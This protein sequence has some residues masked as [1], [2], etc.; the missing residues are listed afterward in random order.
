M[1]RRHP[2]NRSSSPQPGQHAPTSSDAFRKPASTPEATKNL[3]KPAADNRWREWL[4][5]FAL[6]VGAPL[7]LLFI[8]EIPLRVFGYG[9]PASFFI[10]SSSGEKYITNEK[11]A[12]QFS[13]K[14]TP[15]K[16]FPASIPLRKEP[17]AIRI[18]VLGE[19]AAMGTPDPAFGLGRI[20]EVLLRREFP[21]R[22][23]EVIN[24][25][26]RGINSH[27]LRLI[28][29]ECATH[30]VDLFLVYMG[31]NEVI[32]LHGPGPRTPPWAQSRNLIRCSHWFASSKVG[33][34]FENALGGAGDRPHQDMDNFR[35][36]SLRADD[37]R[38]QKNRDIFEANLEDIVRA[39]T[40]SGAQVVLFTV[41]VNLKDFP[42]LQCLHRA[43][44][45]AADQ[46]RWEAAVKEGTE[47]A[48]RG[49]WREAA[50]KYSSALGL[51]DH[52]ADLHFRLAEALLA[53]DD[54]VRARE[55]YQLALDWDALQFR[56]DR[57]MNAVIRKVGGHYAGAG[58]VL[59]DAEEAFASSELSEHGIPGRRLFEDHVHPSFSGNYLLAC[60][61]YEQS[62]AA[63]G[64]ALGRSAAASLPTEA[65]C[66]DTLAYT[67]YDR[68][69][70]LAAMVR[71]TGVPP[72]LDQLN[73]AERQAAA[74]A[75]SRSALAAFN[76]KDAERCF[77][78][79]R[80]AIRQRPDDWVLHYN[81]G[82]FCHEMRRYADAAKELG[83]V[84]KEFPEI[85]RFRVALASA[86]EQAGDKAN[87]AAQLREAL[88]LD[89]KDTEIAQALL[90][91]T[92]SLPNQ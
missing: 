65:E 33:Q 88:K 70:V 25:A 29:Q 24:A 67:L 59:L 7:L 27:A 77:E 48:R 64:P 19:S 4:A 81:L 39:A 44:L 78:I 45:S 12:W 79:Y 56:T 91:V 21:E 46:S 28:A 8:I 53:A 37:P 17:G 92:G 49:Q 16:P 6:V 89:P 61:F 23:F 14:K 66:A 55:H 36:Q 26:M 22:R 51:D 71:M 84:V 62:V 54:P 68:V 30:Q 35:A 74:E 75:A 34:L 69:N 63:L 50:E 82:V 86:L 41:A 72:F 43:G 58:V 20:L 76:P 90:R 13:S 18:C 83:F 52:F 11:F 5:R 87:M 2:Y 38:R 31:N 47:L 10:K 1:S 40:A 60:R 85:K 57:R 80:T 42:P 15:L 73:H 9:Y 32:G 3:N